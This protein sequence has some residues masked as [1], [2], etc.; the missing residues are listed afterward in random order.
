MKKL[1]F[2]LIS[3]CLLV[4]VSPLISQEKTQTFELGLNTSYFTHNTT[5]PFTSL[6]FKN[7]GIEINLETI[8]NKGKVASL[9]LNSNLGW[10][11]HDHFANAFYLD[12]ATGC[13]IKA[14]FGLFFNTDIGVGYQLIFAPVYMYKL[15]EDGEYVRDKIVAR[16]SFI[17]PISFKLGYVIQE[18]KHPVS[19][20]VKYKWFM[21]TPYID[22]VPL[23]PHGALHFGIG[24]RLKSSPEKIRSKTGRK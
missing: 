17:V 8:R 4:Q 19:F 18:M 15:N 21:Q 10:Y 6:S 9:M 22:P 5:L 20:F 14:K 1:M 7:H 11:Y 24:I 13:Q 16:S 2:I 12:F 23:V 3:L